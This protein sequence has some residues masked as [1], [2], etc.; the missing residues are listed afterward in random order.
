MFLTN[1]VTGFAECFYDR[2][3]PTI[4]GG[5]LECTRRRLLPIPLGTARDGRLASFGREGFSMGLAMAL[6]SES[7]FAFRT[8]IV[9]N[10]GSMVTRDGHRIVRQ[11]Q[12][13]GRQCVTRWEELMRQFCTTPN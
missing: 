12:K 6:A 7:D 8:W 4:L 10:S 9:D 2:N 11:D 1:T 5:H 3:I 13:G